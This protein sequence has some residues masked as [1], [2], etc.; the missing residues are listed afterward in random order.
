MNMES[1]MTM[2]YESITPEMAKSILK[3]NVNNRHVSNGLV[4]SYA[5]DMKNGNWDESVGSAISIDVNGNLV[6]GQHRLLAVVQSDETIN[7]WVCR[8]VKPHG[9][10]DN[11]RK[12]SISDQI[13][14]VKPEQ[15][16]I[17]KSS[18][19]ISVA[20][21]LITHLPGENVGGYFRAVTPREVIDYTEAHKKVLDG[22][23]LR[24][25]QRNVAKISIKPVLVGL[26]LAYIG[27]VD[28]K[29]IDT[30]YEILCNG[31][32]TKPEDFP[33]VAYRNYLK[34]SRIDATDEE[35]SRCQYALKK[36]MSGACTRSSKALKKLIWEYPKE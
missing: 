6:D 10:Y 19:Y 28:M 27:G 2:T 35:V 11:N 26:Y 30:F 22:F 34:D 12:R 24:F 36:Y 25:A 8:N 33:I 1:A 20:K 14:I 32:S 31:M 3:N 9:I 23:W 13:G 16:K 7:M 5:N 21:S 29:T 18:R 15:E 17:Y 4:R